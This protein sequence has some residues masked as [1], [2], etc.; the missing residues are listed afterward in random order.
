MCNITEELWTWIYFQR[1]LIAFQ[2]IA[3]N[4]LGQIWEVGFIPEGGK[5]KI[6]EEKESTVINYSMCFAVGPNTDQV[7]ETFTLQERSQLGVKA[8]L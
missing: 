1:S 8:F 5:R 4:F 6:G 3:N 2:I 7:I